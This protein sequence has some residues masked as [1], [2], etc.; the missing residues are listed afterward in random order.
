M[1]HAV[2]E[3]FWAFVL[4]TMPRSL[5]DKRWARVSWGMGVLLLLTA[6]G[7]LLSN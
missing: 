3:M 5:R 7:F 6:L 2:G 4:W 1:A